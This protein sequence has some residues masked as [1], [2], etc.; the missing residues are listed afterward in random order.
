LDAASPQVLAMLDEGEGVSVLF[1]EPAVPAPGM[2][3]GSAITVT[4]AGAPVAGS[5]TRISPWQL[6]WRPSDREQWL[7]GGEYRVSIADL[8]ELGLEQKPVGTNLVPVTFTHLAS[9]SE[10]ILV[11]TQP[12]E[13]PPRA[14]SAFGNTTLFQERL[15]VPELGLYYYRARWYDPQLVNFIERDPAGYADSPNLMQAFR[16][17]PVNRRDPFGLWTFDFSKVAGDTATHQLFVQEVADAARTLLLDPLTR[18]Y[19]RK[20]FGDAAAS[21]AYLRNIASLGTPPRVVYR[22]AVF[23]ERNLSY[24]QG[25]FD[26]DLGVIFLKERW[27]RLADDAATPCGRKFAG[28]GSLADHEFCKFWTWVHA[29][30]LV[31]E[32]I[33]FI[34]EDTDKEPAVDAVT[35]WD[36]GIG[37]YDTGAKWQYLLFATAVIPDEQSSDASQETF[38]IWLKIFRD[39]QL[40]KLFRDDYENRWRQILDLLA[41]D[42]ARGRIAPK[43]GGTP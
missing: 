19:L 11:A 24:A 28:Q 12:P 10:R 5:V 20:R 30:L 9:G 37:G 25:F 18:R 31:H 7:L 35:D 14:S 22:D 1:D 3:L 43:R 42:E 32:T 21:E 34:D 23:W 26:P 6:A 8:V 33:H 40:R 2:E 16:Y 13:T 17:N 41:I 38:F 39:P 4:R 29:T 15:W 27:L 36:K